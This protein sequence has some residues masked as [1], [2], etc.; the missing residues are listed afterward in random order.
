M[1]TGWPFL[2]GVQSDVM[3]REPRVTSRDKLDLISMTSKVSH[4]ENL[5]SHLALDHEKRVQ[6]SSKLLN[7][8]IIH[9]MAPHQERFPVGPFALAQVLDL[10]PKI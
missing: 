9:E 4:F 5:P 10:W 2:G 7:Q 8:A 3:A 1:L 6:M